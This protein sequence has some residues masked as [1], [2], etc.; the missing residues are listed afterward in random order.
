MLERS[1]HSSENQ[2]CPA[3]WQSVGQRL[4]VWVPRSNL[5]HS[6]SNPSSYV[7]IVVPFR[8]NIAKRLVRVEA[9]SVGAMKINIAISWES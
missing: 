2:A 5:R 4:V 9:S 8:A 1:M 3:G 6:C 7:W